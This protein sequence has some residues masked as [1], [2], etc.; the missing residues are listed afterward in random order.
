MCA[1][2]HV[3]ICANTFTQTR[4]Q[5]ILPRA[6]GHSYTHSLLGADAMFFNAGR[7]KCLGHKSSGLKAEGSDEMTN[8]LLFGV[9]VS[10][11]HKW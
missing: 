6:H 8:T 9:S 5:N 2:T 4:T 1:E 7:V 11:F 10:P 3:R